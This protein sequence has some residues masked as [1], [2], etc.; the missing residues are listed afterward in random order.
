MGTEVAAAEGGMT[1][2][3]NNRGPTLHSLA[4]VTSGAAFLATACRTL[5]SSRN[6][7]ATM[8]E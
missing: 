3:R 5:D 4:A 2:G 8:D 1:R 6:T 7:T